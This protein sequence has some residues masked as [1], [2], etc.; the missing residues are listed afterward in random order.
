MSTILNR[1]SCPLGT[2]SQLVV[3]SLPT[4]LFQPNGTTHNV[5]EGS[6]IQLYCS[7]ES[8]TA[9]FSWTKNESL[10]ELDIVHIRERTCNDT[11]TSTSVLTIDG[12]Q[13]SDT[14]TYKCHAVDGVATG[15]GNTVTLT[16]MLES[17]SESI[18]TL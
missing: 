12:F 11:T 9:S 16:G 5:V 6:V 1:R 2:Y 7:V 18:H 15:S 3:T 4:V 10:V 13:F 17:V 14:G 8:T